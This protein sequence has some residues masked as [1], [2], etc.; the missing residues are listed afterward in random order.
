MNDMVPIRSVKQYIREFVVDGGLA[1]GASQKMVRE[2]LLDAFQKEI[3]G[4]LTLKFRDPL[5]LSRPNETVTDETRTAVR[6]I[7]HNANRKWQRLCAEFSRSRAIYSLI[8]PGDLM[9]R[10]KDVIHIQENDRKDEEKPEEEIVSYD[11]TV[12]ILDE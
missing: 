3:F 4:Q 10:M 8:Q 12:Q 6:N 1:K 2:Q 7:L 9:E 11:G 5:L